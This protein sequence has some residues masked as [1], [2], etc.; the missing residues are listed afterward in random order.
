MWSLSVI[1]TI[2]RYSA[3]RPDNQIEY[4]QG[5]CLKELVSCVGLNYKIPQILRPFEGFYSL[6][7]HHIRYFFSLEVSSITL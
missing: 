3:I 7:L 4:Y 5:V 2:K 6:N 1:S